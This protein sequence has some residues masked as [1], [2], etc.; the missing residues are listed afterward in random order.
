MEHF[1]TDFHALAPSYVVSQENVLKWIANAHSKAEKKITGPFQSEFHA[2]VEQQIFRL[3]LGHQKIQTRGVE[4][5]DFL[6]EDWDKMKIF[7]LEGPDSTLEHRSTLFDEI[8]TKK[9]QEFYPEKSS[10]PPHLLHVTCTGYQAPSGAQK[11]VSEKKADTSVTHV[12]HMGCFA[13][14]PAI[15]IARGFSSS[16]KKDV[17]IVHTE[18]CSLHLNPYLHDTDQLVVQTLFADGCIKYTCSQ[19]KGK[20]SFLIKEV[21]DEILPLSLD[22]MSWKCKAW[23]MQMTLQKEIPVI[24][25]R[26]LPSFLKKLCK[27]PSACIS[28]SIFAIHPGGPKIVEQIASIFNLKPHQIAHSQKILFSRGNMSSATLPHIWKEILE[29]SKVPNDANVISLAFGP[30]L[31]VSGILLQKKVFL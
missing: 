28:D 21:Q 22:K 12:Y 15:R 20:G 27:D 18:V 1:L 6:H 13:A 31:T 29:D 26:A 25:A 10:L 17:D 9:F 3:G 5:D 7:N 30:G 4:F 24:V 14:I 19:K 2:K 11:I 8:V 23:G 16:E